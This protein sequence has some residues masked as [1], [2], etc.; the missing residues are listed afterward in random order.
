MGT[1]VK[2]TQNWNYHTETANKLL[3]K[4]GFFLQQLSQ[5]LSKN[6]LK[7]VWLEN[8]LSGSALPVVDRRARV[9]TC[10]WSKFLLIFMCIDIL[11]EIL[12][13]INTIFG[14]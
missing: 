13:L 3:E 7:L 9:F 6:G 8:F 14:I 5:N 4:I 11:G 12:N 1:L 10:W 2:K